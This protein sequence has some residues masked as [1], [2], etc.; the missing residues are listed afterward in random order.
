MLVQK[1]FSARKARLSTTVLDRCDGT[2]VLNLSVSSTRRENF[3][4]FISY[5][6]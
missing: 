2:R 1:R 4:Y 5:S 6:E 3:H